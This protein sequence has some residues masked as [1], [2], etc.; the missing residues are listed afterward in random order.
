M[1]YR[2]AHYFYLLLIPASAFAFSGYLSDIANESG[3]KHVHALSAML[4]ILL[5]A[6][7]SA[8]IHNGRRALHR[9]LGFASLFLF[10][11]YLAGFI[12]VYRSEAMRIVAGDPFAGTFGPGIGFM[13][14]IAVAA[15]A[16]MYYA[17]LRD[18]RNVHLH[19]RWMLVTVLLFSE[20]VMG[21]ILNNTIP[22]LSVN[23]LEDVRHIYEAFHFSQLLAIA[24]AV[25]LYL[26]NRRHGAP[27]VFVIVA[28]VLQSIALELF[29]DVDMW[30]E[31]FLATA[32]W[33]VPVLL[34]IGV[35]L[36]LAVVTAGWHQGKRRTD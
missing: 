18:R 1:P 30:R 8:S 4:W 26:G 23:G 35:T 33:P 24:L 36:G 34:A 29:D 7:Q 13:T 12:L 21:R 22:A 14:L 3:L 9:R 28:L 5:L 11:V 2:Y 10:P 31:S 6:A 20:S 16:Y 15:T 27:F 25:A 19:A 32:A 17:G